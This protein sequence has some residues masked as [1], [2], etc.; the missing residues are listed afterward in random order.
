[1][2]RPDADLDRYLALL[3]DADDEPK[4][5]ALIQ[6]LIAEGARDKLAAKSEPIQTKPPRLAHPLPSNSLASSE[7]PLPL[8]VDPLAGSPNIPSSKEEPQNGAHFDHGQLGCLSRELST[9]LTQ[10]PQTR[11]HRFCRS[12]LVPM[13]LLTRLPSY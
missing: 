1:M 2:R 10:Q 12:L 3:K 5:L 11:F 4:R 8:R 6:L 7:L 13:S 9:P